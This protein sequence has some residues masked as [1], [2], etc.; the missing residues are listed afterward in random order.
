MA[1]PKGPQLTLVDQQLRLICP[2]Q[3]TLWHCG[4][5]SVYIGGLEGRGGKWRR[6]GKRERERGQEEEG[7]QEGEGVA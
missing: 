1:W 2:P 4:Q 6:E 5:D 3:T 7:G